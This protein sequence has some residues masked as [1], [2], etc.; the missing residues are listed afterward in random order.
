M[1]SK[2]PNSFKDVECEILGVGSSNLALAEFLHKEGAHITAR[3]NVPP[4]LSVAE[5]LMF[6][7]DRQIYG[8][9]YLENIKGQYVFRSP[10]IRPDIPEIIAA[11][12]NGS[13]L[14]SEW[15]LFFHRAP[16]R[17]M[18][19]TG[20]DG[21][22]TTVSIAQKIL[23]ASFQGTARKAYAAGNI[24]IPLI[25]L[26]NILTEKDVVIAELSSF[27]LMTLDRSP[28]IAAITNLTPNHLDYHRDMD[29][30]I[31]SK[32][33]IADAGCKQVII[34]DTTPY[35]Q[36]EQ[37]LATKNIQVIKRGFLS[38]SDIYCDNSQIYFHNSAILNIND[39]AISGI[40]NVE[41]Y[42]T[43][44]ALCDNYPINNTIIDVARSFKGVEHRIQLIA[45]IDGIKYYDSSIDSTPSRTATTLACFRKPLT[46]ICG[47]SDKN[48]DYG[49]L[50]DALE[51]YATHVIVTGA[52]AQKILSAINDLPKRSFNVMYKSDFHSAVKLSTQITPKGGTVILSP[53]CASFDA[54]KDYKQRGEVF[55]KIIL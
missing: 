25:S 31:I 11:V 32:L 18:G 43:A 37:H 6:I 38:S 2:Y 40:H 45:E 22:T 35:H 17:I 28:E 53:A 41:N 15:E 48:L 52:S 23:E 39:I 12:A 5:R 9:D 16:C 24:G 54:F 8:K 10:S 20:S 3:A 46:V 47:G 7:T 1:S 42:M 21:K 19:V 50:A 4:S 49:I 55:S 14:G 33:N 13:V 29:E 51:R 34:P 36:I 27:Q 26:L 44:I 30:Y